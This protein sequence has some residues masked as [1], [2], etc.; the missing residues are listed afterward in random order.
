MK[1]VIVEDEKY[2][3]DLIFRLVKKYDPKIQI[4]KILSNVEESVNWFTKND[5]TIDLILMDVQLTD[6][7]S[8]DI[9]EQVHIETPIIFIT[10]FNKYAVNAFRVNSID[11][12]LKPIEYSELKRAF[13][14][15]FN[16]KKNFIKDE[17]QF[18]KKVFANGF[19]P[20]KSRFLIKVGEHYK[21]LKTSSI[22]YFLFEDGVV[23]AQLTNCSQQIID[24]SL[25]E[26]EELL[27]PEKFYRLN[28][29]TIASIDAIG[30]IQNYFNR[31]LSVR[32]LPNDKQ[33]IISRERVSGF[34]VWMNF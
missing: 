32:L 7:V 25:D 9:F 16:L 12:L 10:A 21:F 34:K 11:Y 20:F 24:E 33:E 29:K 19:K 13:D 8:F 5:I 30:S 23:L 26:L 1:V 3:S 4:V 18:Y 22:S 27:D 14:K 15:Y 31:R 28:R 6:G 2:T 17:P